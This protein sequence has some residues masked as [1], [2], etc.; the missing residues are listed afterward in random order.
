MGFRNGAYATV[1]EVKPGFS[2]SQR[3][4]LSITRKDKNTQE[5]VSEF[6]GYCDFWGTAAAK[7][8]RLKTKDRIKLVNVDVTNRY[9][10]KTEKE[11]INFKVFDFE[12]ADG[13]PSSGG[14]QASPV[15]GN[16][17][18]GDASEDNVPF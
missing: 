8:Q 7:A 13:Q 15:A 4:R 14:G 18:E 2:T 12:P 9:D 3:C 10:K 1:W 17:Y 11:Y 6:S 16:L 5:L